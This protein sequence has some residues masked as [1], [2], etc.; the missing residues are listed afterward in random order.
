MICFFQNAFKQ[1]KND[2]D[3]NREKLIKTLNEFNETHRNRTEKNF[4]NNEVNFNKI[5]DKFENTD[6]ALNSY[7]NKVIRKKSKICG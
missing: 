6:I 5:H 4:D 7:F 2:I 3:V 1:I